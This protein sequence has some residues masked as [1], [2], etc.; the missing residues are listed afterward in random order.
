MTAERPVI[1]SGIQP[2]GNLTLG[3][4][5][6]ALKNWVSLQGKYDC[7]FSL[8]DLHT[9]TVR[10]D[11]KLFKAHCYDALAIYLA[12][13]IDHDQHSVFLQ[14]HIPAHTQLA[15]ILNCYS[16]MGELSRMTQFKDKATKNEANINVGLFSYPVLM[17][18]DI[19]LYDTN[20]VPVGADQKQHVELARDLAL[21]FNNIYGEVFTVPEIYHPPL[22]ARIMSLQ[23]PTKK[24]SKSDENPH[25]TVFLLDSPDLIASKCKRAVTDSGKEIYF[26]LKKKPGVSNLLT[27]L[28]TVSG[29]TVEQWVDELHSHGYGKLKSMVTDNLIEFLQPIQESYRELRA[30]Q[31]RLDAVLENGARSAIKRSQKILEKVYEVLGFVEVK[32]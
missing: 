13:G 29:K 12:V 9:I 14:S 8:V 10:Q 4:Y 2:S 5:L 1:F 31:A 17:A 24:M 16:Y 3:N 23:D 30:D 19:L 7:L 22:G 32:I 21:R 20:L 18:A 28:A 27:I 6:G 15:W 11:P 25:A 26:D